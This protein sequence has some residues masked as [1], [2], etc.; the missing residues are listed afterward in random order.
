MTLFW[1][2]RII[3]IY[4]FIYIFGCLLFISVTL[5]SE[6]FFLG[7]VLAPLLMKT[8]ILAYLYPLPPSTDVPSP[9]FSYA[10]LHTVY[11]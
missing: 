10:G 2:S 1:T 7:Y 11:I 9:Y 4:L 3:F 6:D 5:Q 8:K